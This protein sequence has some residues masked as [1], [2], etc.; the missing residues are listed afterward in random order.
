MKTSQIFLKRFMLVMVGVIYFAFLNGCSVFMAA[1]QPGY[2]NLS[3]LTV[4][5][6]RADVVAELG[7]PVLSEE[8]DGKKKDVIVF[9]QGYSKGNKTSRALFHGVADIFSLG[10]WEII[11]TPT[12]I[13]ADGRDVRVEVFYDANENVEKVNYLQ[14][15]Q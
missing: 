15:K 11:G 10:L 13:I 5:N 4:G 6:R 3:V 1:K 14:A 12:E 7:A 2:K 8:K 9:R